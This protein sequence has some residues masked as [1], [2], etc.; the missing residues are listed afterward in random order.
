MIPAVNARFLRAECSLCFFAYITAAALGWPF[1]IAPERDAWMCSRMHT[2]TQGEKEGSHHAAVAEPQP[3]L[4]NLGYKT[5]NWAELPRFQVSHHALGSGQAPQIR[6]GG[7]WG[8]APS[9]SGSVGGAL[10][11]SMLALWLPLLDIDL[12]NVC[13]L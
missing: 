6:T 8:V 9:S 13:L 12:L 4:C 11:L 1:T 2:A 3:E 10:Q 5:R 7:F